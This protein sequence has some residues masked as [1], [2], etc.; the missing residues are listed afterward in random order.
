MPAHALIRNWWESGVSPFSEA[1]SKHVETILAGTEH[2]SWQY[3]P[4][5]EL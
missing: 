3:K 4:L 2:T 1:F 5:A